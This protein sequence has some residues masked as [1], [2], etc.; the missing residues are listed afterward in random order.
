MSYPEFREEIFE[1]VK[2]MI[3]E[4]ITVELV[5][6][7]KLNSCIR[8]GISF[9]KD[10]EIFSPT[11]YL[12]P[13]YK[14]FQNGQSIDFLVEEL[15][16]CYKEETGQLPDCIRKLDSYETARPDIYVKLIHIAENRTLLKDTPHKVFLDFAIVPYFEVNEEQ[17]FKGSVLLKEHYPEAWQ[18]SAEDMLSY[19]ITHTR[20]EKGVL[21]QSMSEVLKDLIS[22]NDGELFESAK[23][24]M[25]VL[26]NKEKYLGAVLIYFPDVLYDISTRLKEDFYMLPASV[27]EWV[28]V[29]VSRVEDER[30]LFSMVKDINDREVLEEE[31]LSYYVYYY[32]INSQ[33]IHICESSKMKNC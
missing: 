18:V 1:A 3:S 17:I 20:Q 4:D 7:D 5:Q 23:E 28:I 27:H 10:G 14:S 33:K 30:L 6:V 21:F 26:T 16:R 29:P 2:G 9:T 13:F 31:I 19:A 22:E 8:Y 25:F 15:F 11:I 24:E 32:S 12:E